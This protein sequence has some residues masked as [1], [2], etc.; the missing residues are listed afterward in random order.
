[1][2]AAAQVLE[3]E[4]HPFLPGFKDTPFILYL[5]KSQPKYLERVY[6]EQEITI[7]R[8]WLQVRACPCALGPAPIAQCAACAHSEQFSMACTM[9]FCIC[10]PHHSRSKLL[11]LSFSLCSQGLICHAGRVDQQ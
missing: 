6:F 9:T 7:N 5:L 3:Q 1:V 2:V 11:H 10:V 8:H 4:I